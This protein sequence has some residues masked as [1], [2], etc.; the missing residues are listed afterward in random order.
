MLRP[1]SGGALLYLGVF[2]CYSEPVWLGGSVLPTGLSTASARCSGRTDSW[3]HGGDSK[4]RVAL[5]IQSVLCERHGVQLLCGSVRVCHWPGV[6][7]LQRPVCSGVLLPT[8]VRLQS[9]VCVRQRECV[10]SGG[11]RDSCAGVARE[12]LPWGS[13]A[14]PTHD[15]GSMPSRLILLGWRE[16]T[17][18]LMSCCC[19]ALIAGLCHCA[20]TCALWVS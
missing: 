7:R 14:R 19:C 3:R 16:G 15:G 20:C 17:G 13:S 9:S 11:V 12:L 1:V 5:S 6:S 18:P 2:E 4:R 8:W 10:L